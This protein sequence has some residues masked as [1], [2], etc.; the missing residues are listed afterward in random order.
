MFC[1]NSFALKPYA[2]ILWSAIIAQWSPDP[3][4]GVLRLEVRWKKIGLD[5]WRGGGM[6]KRVEERWRCD[7]VVFG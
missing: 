5:L 7:A 3:G 2:E 4:I 1:Q 6:V